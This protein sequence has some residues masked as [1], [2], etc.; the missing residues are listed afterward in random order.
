[1]FWATIVKE[2]TAHLP[3]ATHRF[4]PVN[5]HLPARLANSCTSPPAPPAR[6]RSSVFLPKGPLTPRPLIGAVTT[7]QLARRMT[8]KAA[9]LPLQTTKYPEGNHVFR[10]ATKY[11]SRIHRW[12]L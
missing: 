5:V 3:G 2:A 12:H 4:L 1:V 10:E 8:A 7:V 11:S 6:L 9:A